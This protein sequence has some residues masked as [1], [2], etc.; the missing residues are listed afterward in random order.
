MA[1]TSKKKV[2]I[3][4]FARRTSRGQWRGVGKKWD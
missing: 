4:G 3:K 1:G 2:A